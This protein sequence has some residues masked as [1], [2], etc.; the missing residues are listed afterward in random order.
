[1]LLLLVLLPFVL[2][3]WQ[4]Q[5]GLQKEAQ[6]RT[7]AAAQQS[8]PVQLLDFPVPARPSGRRVELVGIPYG[9]PL[10]LANSQLDGV[11]GVR[12]WQPLLLTDGTAVLAELGWLPAD[13]GGALPTLSD[14]LAGL[15]VV[16]PRRMTL[17][18]ARIAA[19]GEIDALDRDAL[20]RE[21][22]RPLR[23]GLVRLSPVPAPLRPW[24][25]RNGMEP[26]RHYGY[27][28]QWGLLG[29]CLLTAWIGM[30]GKPGG[31]AP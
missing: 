13:H 2:A 19:K 25:V 6:E 23:Q 1:M 26:A 11:P 24:P 16:E 17:G 10:R 3:Y 7:L 31:M 5:R 4:W 9:E 22:G 27:A 12:V 21:L 8:R 30:M 20:Q 28:V 29:G 15:W 14:H 18:G